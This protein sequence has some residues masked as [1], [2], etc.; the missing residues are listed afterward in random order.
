MASISRKWL[1]LEQEF[2]RHL[3]VRRD[4]LPKLHLQVKHHRPKIA[5]APHLRHDF[6]LRFRVREK[7]QLPENHGRGKPQNSAILKDQSR[8]RLFG[9]EFAL[10]AFFRRA[11]AA[12]DNLHL[13]SNCIPPGIGRRVFRGS[14]RAL[15]RGRVI[16]MLGV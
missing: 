15:R 6:P 3:D 14:F 9:E 16:R 11:R 7:Q 13:A 4:W 5:L 8:R 10:A 1:G 12:G 2:H